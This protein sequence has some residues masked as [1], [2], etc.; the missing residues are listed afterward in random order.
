MTSY[1]V[2]GGCGFIGVN[3]VSRLAA[4]GDRVRILDNLSLGR[5]EDVEGFGAEVLVGDI[6]DPVIVKKAMKDVEVVVHFAAH[7]RVVESVSDPK[8]NFDVNAVGTMN[9]LLASKTVGV[10]KFIFASTGGAIL[11]E[12]DPPVHEGM[13]PRPVSPYGAGKLAG[14][15]YCSAFCGS[16][17]LNTVALRFSNV[18]GPYSYHKGSVVAQF[19]KN[20]MQRQPLVVYGKGEQTRD[21][22]YV[23][24]L[25]DAVLLAD[26]AETPGEVFQIASGRETSIATLIERMKE[27][28][29]SVKF[30]IRHEEARSG[31]IFRNYASIDKARRSLGYEPKMELS[32]GLRRTWEW[33]LSRNGA[34]A[35]KQ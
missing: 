4:R 15:A 25:V 2:T 28:L 8:L 16:F 33:F 26:R 32:E 11:G 23:D 10:R 1:L 12:Q 24:D 20:L 19:F 27:L 5:K 9:M 22:L 35:D 13:V 17:G 30:Q 14:E 31:E 34:I 18:Y 29:P 6:L 3:L 21:F 7:T